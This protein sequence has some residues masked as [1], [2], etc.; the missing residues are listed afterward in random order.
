VRYLSKKGEVSQLMSQLRNIPN[1]ER[2]QFGANINEL[3]LKIEQ[4]WM[5]KKQQLEDALF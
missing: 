3:K 2:P 4:A 1:E 5:K